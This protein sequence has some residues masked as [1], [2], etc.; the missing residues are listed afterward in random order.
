MFSAIFTTNIY[1]YNNHDFLLP[2]VEKIEMINEEPNTGSPYEIN[3]AGFTNTEIKV[4]ADK[5]SDKLIKIVEQHLV[6]LQK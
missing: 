1:S 6:E 4:I 2:E 3:K 5:I